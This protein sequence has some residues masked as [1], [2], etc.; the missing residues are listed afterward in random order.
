MVRLMVLPATSPAPLVHVEDWARHWAVQEILGTDPDALN[1]DRIG[2]TLEAIAPNLKAMIEA[3]V[4]FIA[5]GSKTHVSG[6]HAGRAD[7][8]TA[9]PGGRPAPGPRARGERCAPG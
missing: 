4:E 7:P 9:R 5:P 2:R 1:D 6:H 8:G 3:G